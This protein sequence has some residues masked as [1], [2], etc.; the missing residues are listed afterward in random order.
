MAFWC[1]VFFCSGVGF[2]ISKSMQIGKKKKEKKFLTEVSK[3]Q[4]VT[5][6]GEA[7]TERCIATK[8]HF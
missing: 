4:I 1:F 2:Y 8:L 5:L 6:H 3:A 7:Y